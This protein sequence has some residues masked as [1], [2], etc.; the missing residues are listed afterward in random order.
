MK[1]SWKK[2]WVKVGKG[3]LIGAFASV[4]PAVSNG[5]GLKDIMYVLAGSFIAGAFEGTRNYLKIK[6]SK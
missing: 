2:W 1:F 6:G 5:E 3:A 4:G